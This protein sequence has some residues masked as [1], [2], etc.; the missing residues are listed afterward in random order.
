MVVVGSVVV[1]VGAVV[2]GVVAVGPVVAGVWVVGSVAVGPVVV[3]LVVVGVV[4]VAAG[5]LGLGFGLGFGFVPTRTIFGS[6]RYEEYHVSS[7]IRLPL[8]SYTLRCTLVA[9]D[10]EPPSSTT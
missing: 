7:W 1:V 9:S 6:A 5:G 4:V 10:G 8:A 3:G 2:A